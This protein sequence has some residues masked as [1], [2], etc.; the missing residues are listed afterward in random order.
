MPAN[1]TEDTLQKNND[2]TLQEGSLPT[3][4]TVVYDQFILF[5]DSIT[6]I[7]GDPALGFSCYQAFQ[8]GMKT[9]SF[10]RRIEF[11]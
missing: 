8:H 6:Q 9:R 10:S 7:D 4:P 2:P 5:G 11:S 3:P 1:S